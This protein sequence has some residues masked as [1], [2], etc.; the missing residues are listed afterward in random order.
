MTPWNGLS[1]NREE[2]AGPSYGTVSPAG[3][4]SSRYLKVH[5]GLNL[6]AI[7]CGLVSESFLLVVVL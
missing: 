3:Q 2:I 5:S 7:Q 6:G 4:E 1:D